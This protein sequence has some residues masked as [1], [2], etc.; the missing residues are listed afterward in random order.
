MVPQA[1]AALDVNMQLRLAGMARIPDFGHW[2]ARCDHIADT[3]PQRPLPQMREI[4]EQ[5]TAF[6][7]DFVSSPIHCI[8]FRHWQV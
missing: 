3:H 4:D 7:H 6:D 2:R 8:K 5:V 1:G